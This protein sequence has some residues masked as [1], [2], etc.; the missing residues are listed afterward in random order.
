MEKTNIG[1][2]PEYLADVA[3]SLNI[4]L[5]DEHILYIKTRNA[6]WNVEGPDFH[7]MHLFFEA[8]YG[9]LEEVIDEIAERIR[10]IGHFAVASLKEYLELTHLTEQP[11]EKNNSEGFIRA[12]LEDHETIIMHLRDSV[13]RYAD[14]WKDVGTSDF[15][16]GYLEKHEKMAWMLSAHLTTP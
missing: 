3:H 11:W 12:L 4:L 5:A 14:E 2:K 16:T 1:I 8:Q 15:I 13:T 6:H 9:E 10:S 7:A